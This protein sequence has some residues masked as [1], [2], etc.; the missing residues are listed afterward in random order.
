MAMN[1]GKAGVL[2]AAKGQPVH[3]GYPY[4]MTLHSKLEIWERDV[5]ERKNNMTNPKAEAVTCS[6]NNIRQTVSKGRRP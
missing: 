6:G 4:I 2:I 1:C 3:S 5:T